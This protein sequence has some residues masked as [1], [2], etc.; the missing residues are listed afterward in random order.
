[1][2]TFDFTTINNFRQHLNW[3]G[4]TAISKDNLSGR[5]YNFSVGLT[6]YLGK[7]KEHA[8]WVNSTDHKLKVFSDSLAHKR[9]DTIESLLNDM[10]KEGVPDYLDRENNT[11]GGVAVDT[12][13][14]FLDTNNNGVPD[15]LEKNKEK[16]SSGVLIN[17]VISVENELIERGLINVFFDSNSIVPS[18]SSTNNLYIL[19]HYMQ[20][21]PEVKLRLK[22]YADKTGNESSNI[23]LS[24]LRA[25]SVYD[26]L[27]A[28]KVSSS[29]ISIEGNG[30]DSNFSNDTKVNFNMARRVSIQVY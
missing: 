3:D 27:V 5:L 13:G 19:L 25:Q 16:V 7:K 17:K 2:L 14:R 21:N 8:D 23:Q 11:P 29:R 20:H 26:F 9:I 6:Y 10:D 28:N 1:V 30:V 15:E 18:P 4:S 22:G 24:K 12:R